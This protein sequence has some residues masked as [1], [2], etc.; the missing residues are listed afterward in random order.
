MKAQAEIAT[1]LYQI[2]GTIDICKQQG[3]AVYKEL[4][5]L[6]VQV[7]QKLHPVCKQLITNWPQVI[8][9]Y[10]ADFFEYE[11]R[12]RIIKQSLTTQSLSGTRIAKVVIPKYKDWGDLL[13]WQMQ[14][15]IPG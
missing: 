13:R 2:Q 12:G 4:E 11:V 7:E 5:Q 10:N 8:K 14:E 3:M 15:N 6:Q 9:K 1:T